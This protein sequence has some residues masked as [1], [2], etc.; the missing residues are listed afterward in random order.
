[1]LEHPAAGVAAEV[2]GHGADRTDRQALEHEDPAD[3][4]A[5]GPH[6]LEDGNVLPLLHHDHDQGRQDG[7]GG[8]QDDEQ[9][10]DEVHRLL[11]L[12]DREQ[13]VV[14]LDPVAHAIGRAECGAHPRGHLRGLVQVLHPHLDVVHR[15]SQTVQ[16]LGVG[17]ADVG[18]AGVVL[19]HARVEDAG[20]DEAREPRHQG[21][22]PCAAERQGDVDRLADVDVEPPRQLGAEDDARQANGGALPLAEGNGEVMRELPDGALAHVSPEVVRVRRVGANAA[23]EGS[24]HVVGGGDHELGVDQRS[25]VDHAFDASDSRQYLVVALDHAHAVPHHHVCIETENAVPQ[26]L[27]EPGHDRQHDVQGHHA[28]GDADRRDQGDERDEDLAALGAQVP[29]PDEQLVSHGGPGRGPN[30]AHSTCR[31]TVRQAERRRRTAD[32]RARVLD[33]PSGR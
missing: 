22:L 11:Q 8:D 21:G 31:T 15:V 17:E 20:D 30:H 33:P 19:R 5:R 18:E 23:Q 32:R 1:M 6:R 10:H 9:K 29:Q 12:Q 7:E 4:A 16:T 27:L 2:S 25:R 28:D 24:G 14:G 3:R 13:V 26:V